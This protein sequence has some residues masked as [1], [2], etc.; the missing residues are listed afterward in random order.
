MIQGLTGIIS[1]Q[2]NPEIPFPDLIRN[3]YADKS[4]A[5]T[6]AQ[7]ITAA[8]LVREKGGGGQHVKV[9]MLD[10]AMY[11][12]WP[13]GMMDKT[14]LDDDASPGFL[15]STVYNLTE[16]SDGKIVYFAA[17]D[18][19]RHGLYRTLGHPEWVEDPRFCDIVAI[20]NPE[21]F[22]A[23]GELLA[24]A[25][26]AIT[27]DDAL[28]RLLAADV[29][30]GPVLDADEAIADPQIVHNET[31]VTWEHA[32][33]GHIRQPRPAARFSATPAEA[34]TTASLRGEDNDAILSELGCS[35]TEIATWRETGIIN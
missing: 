17:S 2:M 32:S 7:A 20:A 27:V 30:S 3:L 31:L 10:A 25:F 34:A 21:N 15:L 12:F 33:A 29:P 24:E 13:D 8:L 14:M 23:L 11:F 26:A 5:L 16:C 35:A 28:E 22:A 6:V 18:A 19:H 9:P 1:R 4:T